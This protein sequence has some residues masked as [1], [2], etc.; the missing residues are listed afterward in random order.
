M[1]SLAVLGGFL[2]Y[3]VKENKVKHLFTVDEMSL[4]V[5]LHETV[6]AIARNRITPPLAVVPTPGAE[7][8]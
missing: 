8:C 7:P 6:E 4:A 3:G 2:V 1:A 5:G